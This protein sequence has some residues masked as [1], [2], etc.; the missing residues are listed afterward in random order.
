M[1]RK[2]LILVLALVL[3]AELLAAGGIFY[4]T[5]LGRESKT[6]GTLNS[7]KGRSGLLASA[8]R[9]FDEKEEALEEEETKAAEEKPQ[10]NGLIV[11]ID[12]GH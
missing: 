4:K 8:V 9:F 6:E 12:P 10:L 3:I 1:K 5:Y 11:A 7:E 2:G